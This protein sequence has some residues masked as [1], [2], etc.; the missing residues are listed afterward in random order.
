MFGRTAKVVV[1]TGL[2]H[3]PIAAPQEVGVLL[4]FP[5]AKI[6]DAGPADGHVSYIEVAKKLEFDPSELIV[7]ELNDFFAA[8][9]FADLLVRAWL[10]LD[11][12]PDRVGAAVV[13]VVGVAVEVLQA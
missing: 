3:V 5:S 2:S 12:D 10:E 4:N 6:P 1:P 13:A 7:V 9:S 11:L 8:E